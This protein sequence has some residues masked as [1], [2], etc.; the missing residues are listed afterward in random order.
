M[1]G[2]H[3]LHSENRAK[4]FSLAFSLNIVAVSCSDLEQQSVHVQVF[5]LDWSKPD[6]SLVVSAD[7]TGFLDFVKYFCFL[8]IFQICNKCGGRGIIINL[9]INV[10]YTV[11]YSL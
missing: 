11:Q 8:Q 6:P 7:E 4:V 10:V 9:H 3:T 1:V 5:G 2:K